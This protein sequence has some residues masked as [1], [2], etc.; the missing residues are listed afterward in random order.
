MNEEKTQILSEIKLHI[1]GEKI[2]LQS[3]KTVGFVLIKETQRLIFHFA[4][5]NK[6]HREKICHIVVNSLSVH[7]YPLIQGQIVEQRISEVRLPKQTLKGFTNQ[8]V[9]T[10]SYVM[11]LYCVLFSSHTDSWTFS[12]KKHPS[13]CNYGNALCFSTS[14]LK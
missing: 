13:V 2:Q 9:N 3:C 10:S 12:L 4:D 7:N 11:C 8:R 6:K 14:V 1:C 5:A